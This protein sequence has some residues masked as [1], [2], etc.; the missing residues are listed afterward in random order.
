MAV[1]KSKPQAP[2]AA[3]DASLT[4]APK[5]KRRKPQS[6]TLVIPLASIRVGKRERAYH[7]EHVQ[8]LKLNI[9][10]VGLINPITVARDPD[11]G[12]TLVA[13][14]HRLE[15]FR[16]LCAEGNPRYET[17][18]VVVTASANAKKVEWSENLYRNDLTVLEKSEHLVAYLNAT[19]DTV[20][21]AIENLSKSSGQSRRT[22]FRYKAIGTGIQVADEIKAL[23]GDLADSTR[24]LYFLATQCSKAEQKAVVRELQR[25][26][27]LTAQQAY[28]RVTGQ[29]ETGAPDKAVPVLMPLSVREELSSLAKARQMQKGE[30]LEQFMDA[31]LKAYKQGSFGLE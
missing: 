19:G 23:D 25:Y 7:P 20:A 2:A 8:E 9:E 27:G 13:G 30:F 24:Q 26:P 21:Q 6:E 29:E 22:F 12:Y 17:V 18:P 11:G 5:A 3:A 15:A 28:A 10:D 31:A 14:R 1:S 4:L 16:E